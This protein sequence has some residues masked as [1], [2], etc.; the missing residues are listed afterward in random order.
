MSDVP[1]LL[2][3]AEVAT[4]LRVSRASVSRW[5]KDGVLKPIRIGGTLRFRRA[6]VDA[7]LV[8]GEPAGDAA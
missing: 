5:A 8:P 7:L 1:D 4:R 3:P 6:D 2:T